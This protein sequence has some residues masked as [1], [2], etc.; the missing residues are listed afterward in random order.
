M[1]IEGQ[2]PK[3]AESIIGK[4][5]TGPSAQYLVKW[6][7]LPTKESSWEPV[8]KITN[9]RQLIDSYNSSQALDVPQG[10]QEKNKDC[11]TS[12]TIDLQKEEFNETVEEISDS[13]VATRKRGRPSIF[14]LKPLAKNI[15]KPLSSSLL[16][17]PK[18]QHDYLDSCSSKSIELNRV[19]SILEH[20]DFSGDIYLKMDC[21]TNEKKMIANFSQVE[22][23]R[24]ELISAYCK[25][26]ILK[27]N[28]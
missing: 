14:Q 12:I 11:S 2:A 19:L 25:T 6:K 4:V 13:P 20:F 21:G 7:G 22:N 10:F 1:N 9:F 3:E 27:Y 28:L 18:S 26:L 16:P 23:A 5:G 17:A 15:K 24:P 8:S